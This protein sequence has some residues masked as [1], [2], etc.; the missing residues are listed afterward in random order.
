VE[1]KPPS[2]NQNRGLPGYSRTHPHRGG[3]VNTGPHTHGNH[4]NQT[5]TNRRNLFNS[6]GSDSSEGENDPDYIPRPF[7]RKEITYSR[8]GLEDFDFSRHNRTRFGGLEPYAS[9]AYSN[10]LLQ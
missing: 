2:H 4:G 8:L 1:W 7:R 3:H 6:N 10:A 5:Y 9:N